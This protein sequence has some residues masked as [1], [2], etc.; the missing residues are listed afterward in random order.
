MSDHE[1]DSQSLDSDCSVLDPRSVAGSICPH[2]YDVMTARK[3]SITHVISLSTHDLD[4]GV[5]LARS[6]HG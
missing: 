3:I 4:V 5:C 1:A 2:D 6:W